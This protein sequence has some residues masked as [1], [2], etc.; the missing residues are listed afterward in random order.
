M[1]QLRC[2][3]YVLI[4]Q[5]MPYRSGPSGSYAEIVPLGKYS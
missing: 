3:T 4:F 5:D 2:I 1:I